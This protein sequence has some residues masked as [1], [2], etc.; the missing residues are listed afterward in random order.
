PN[1]NICST[2]NFNVTND[3]AGNLAGWGWNDAVGWISFNCNNSVIGNTCATSDYRVLLNTTTGDFSGWAWNDALGWISFNC[4][5]TSTCGTVSYKVSQN[6]SG[7]VAGNL[8]SSTFDTGYSNGVSFNSFLWQGSLPTDS[9]VKFQL[10]TANCSNGATDAPGCAAGVG[11]GGSKT[12]GDGAFLGSDGSSAT[13]YSPS[14]PNSP[15]QI[16]GIYHN[17]K[18][19]YRYK[20][21]L[22]GIYTLPST[23]ID[24]VN[25]WAWN[26]SFGW[27][28]FFS[29]GTVNIT[30]SPPM[31]ISAVPA[32][33]TLPMTAPAILPAG[34]GTMPLAG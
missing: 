34:A 16:A 18:R 27:M 2:S 30:P 7:P 4:S 13:Y 12:A 17:N 23:G 31:A 5:N 11:W 26:D 15:I 8:I 3:G 1:G 20:V 28:N 19:Y 29:P 9:A 14:G 25:K 22:D 33:S 21:F 6:I 32:T 24:S 10:A